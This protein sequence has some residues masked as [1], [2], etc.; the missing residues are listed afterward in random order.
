MVLHF[1]VSG[2]GEIDVN[3]LYRQ[4]RDY[5]YVKT[6]GGKVFSLMSASGESWYL[7]S[8]SG[9]QRLVMYFCKEGTAEDT[10][11]PSKGWTTSEGNV[12]APQ[13]IV[14]EDIEI[15]ESSTKSAAPPEVPK[16][17]WAAINADG[18][19]SYF[20]LA[21]GESTWDKPLGFD[22]ELQEL[23]DAFVKPEAREGAVLPEAF[24]ALCDSSGM[25]TKYMLE[26]VCSGQEESSLPVFEMACSLK[27]KGTTW[28]GH[29]IEPVGAFGLNFVRLEC[30]F[31]DSSGMTEQ[32][33]LL[34]LEGLDCVQSVSV[35]GTAEF[36]PDPFER[37]LKLFE[38][39]SAA[40][41]RTLFQRLAP[42]HLDE[43]LAS[44]MT[45]I[46][47]FVSKEVVAEM[48]ALVRRSLNSYRSSGGNASADDGLE[49]H[50]PPP[51]PA[52]SDIIT[53]LRPDGGYGEFA[54]LVQPM[55]QLRQDLQQCMPVLKSD[56]EFQLA[57][58]PPN[59]TGYRRHTD[60]LPYDIDD[61]ASVV[62][63]KV[64]TI[65][66]LNNEWVS[67]HGGSLRIWL[68]KRAGAGWR[69]LE[70]V[71]GRLVIF[72]SGCMPHEVRPSF[73]ADRFALTSWI[74]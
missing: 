30:T 12:P 40:E 32:A 58:Y 66:Y 63:R 10:C 41:D 69:E 7:Q 17:E 72:L 42:A 62:E 55:L 45:V 21:T 73:E 4:V 43:L 35:K 37:C 74:T 14:A 1:Q 27:L 15:D 71:A 24:R 70:P 31:S 25:K 33:I 39:G 16:K 52:R 2:A 50:E 19:T 65:L 44:G 57:C 68:P 29:D 49:W 5:E 61:E 20:C 18:V 26:V 23:Q 3:G 51:R 59:A 67:N 48:L 36:V 46:D 13:S 34:A 22:E 56:S 38:G 60:A 47:D 6:E 53:W 64:T 28:L 11:P 54:G 8:F 9:G